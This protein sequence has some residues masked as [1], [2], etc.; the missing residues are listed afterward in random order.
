[1]K[2]N[3]G[4][5]TD[6]QDAFNALVEVMRRLRAPDGCPWDR[7]QTLETLKTYCI[8]EAYEVVQ[9]IEDGDRDELCEE[10]GDLMM[11]IVFQSGITEDEGGFDISDVCRGAA[12]KLVSRHPHVFG[13]HKAKDADEVLSRWETY[14]RKEGKGVLA[15]VPG[16]LPALLMALRVSQKV[17]RVGFDWPDES[18]AIDKMDE[19]VAELKEALRSG[20]D[21]AVEEEIGDVLFTVA[22]LARI[23]GLDPE[24][25]LRKMLARFKDRFEH[26]EARLAESGEEVS[27][28]PLPTLDALWEEAKERR[29]R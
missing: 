11:Q 7:V 1:V 4:S 22:N 13:D 8:E 19:E 3:R 21:R 20:D 10:L 16:Q 26:I 9:A 27:G 15:G 17:G 14:K 23:K 18:G 24:E 25:S 29:K 28:T 12:D 2:H 5:D 6:N